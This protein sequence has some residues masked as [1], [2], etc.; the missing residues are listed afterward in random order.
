MTD[1]QPIETAPKDGTLVLLANSLQSAPGKWAQGNWRAMYFAPG[2]PDEFRAGAGLFNAVTHWMPMPP[3]PSD[4][5]LVQSSIHIGKSEA[6]QQVYP[7]AERV[8]LNVPSSQDD[9]Q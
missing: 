6:L 8:S 9:T 1:W 7:N 2:G 4:E 5:A 3:P